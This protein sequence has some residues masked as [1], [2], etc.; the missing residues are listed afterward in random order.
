MGTTTCCRRTSSR[1]SRDLYVPGFEPG[2]PGAPQAVYL[3]LHGLDSADPP[4]LAASEPIYGN[5]VTGVQGGDWPW[6]LGGRDVSTPSPQTLQRYQLGGFLPGFTTA[7][8][9]ALY[10]DEGVVIGAG[11]VNPATD[12]RSWRHVLEGGRTLF[13]PPPWS[14]GYKRLMYSPHH[15]Y[16]PRSSTV[17]NLSPRF[18]I[19]YAPM[20]MHHR[21]EPQ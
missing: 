9:E 14:M 10:V 6:I 13:T 15:P 21:G 1:P 12:K 7:D 4:W 3:R 2:R 8:L 17:R 19:E 20:V 11:N 16:R 5:D 18:G